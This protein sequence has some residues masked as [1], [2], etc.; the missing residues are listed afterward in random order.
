MC[1]M[2]ESYH[3]CNAHA[4]VMCSMLESYHVCNVHAGVLCSM[5]VISC[6]QCPCRGHVQYADMYE[7]LRNMEPPVG[8][9]KKCPYRLAYRVSCDFCERKWM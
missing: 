7:M 9:G 3:V 5:L 8:F 2:L 4:G 1:S 6:M